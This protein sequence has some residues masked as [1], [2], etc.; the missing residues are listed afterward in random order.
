M[1]D[2]EVAHLGLLEYERARHEIDECRL[3]LHAHWVAFNH[4]GELLIDPDEWDSVACQLDRLHDTYPV[5]VDEGYEAEW[6][7]SWDTS[8][9]N[10]LPTTPYI[11]EIANNMVDRRE[12]VE[13]RNA[14]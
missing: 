2:L 5:L 6:F 12:E 3:V 8:N 4:L 1:N 13:G 14:A 10:E 11:L 9:W 7:S